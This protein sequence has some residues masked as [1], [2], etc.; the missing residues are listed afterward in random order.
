MIS[1]CSDVF[2]G[3][4]ESKFAL[5]P[6]KTLQGLF[7]SLVASELD[8]NKYININPGN[9]DILRTILRDLVR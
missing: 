2:A 4:L 9:P 8:E 7:G 3:R 6:A 5:D 1:C